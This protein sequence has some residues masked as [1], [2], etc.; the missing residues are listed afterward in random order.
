[1]CADKNSIGGRTR[2]VGIVGW[3]VEHSL[4]PAMHNAAFAALGLD[5]AY[6]PLPVAPARVD[7]AVR[8]LRALGFAGA[9]VTIPHK[10]AVMS[11]LDEVSGAARAIGAVNTIVVR[12]GRLLGENTDWLGFLASLREAGFEPKGKRALVLGAGGAA[13]AVV[14]AL[15]SVGVEVAVVNR[16]PERVEILARELMELG[17]TQGNSGELGG[18]AENTDG[19]PRSSSEFLRVPIQTAPTIQAALDLVNGIHLVV[20]TTPV[21]MWPRVDASPWPEEVLLP[22]GA[23]V[24]D[25]VYNPLET[26]LLQ[27]A[28]AAGCQVIDGLG[29][30]V[31]QGAAA[32]EM[33]TGVKAPVEVMRRALMRKT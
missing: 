17:G 3:P 33:W 21:G 22:S 26:Q 19:V 8:G 4:S 2:L 5:W 15:A 11:Q 27:R 31:H 18:I 28:R 7:E 25:L 32:F 9:N 29:M 16:T 30:L 10:Q 14:Y 20:N 6:V 12:E 1:M 13:R 23:A 24:C